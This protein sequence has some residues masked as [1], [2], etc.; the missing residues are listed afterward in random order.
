[1]KLYG[2]WPAKLAQVLFGLSFLVLFMARD[3]NA[4]KKPVP[5]TT[6]WSHRHLVFSTP[7]S[8]TRQIRLSSN[9]RYAQQSIR[10]NAQ[11]RVDQKGWRWRRAPEKP[12]LLQGDWSIYMGPGATVGARNYPAKYSFD[13]TSVRCAADSEG[14]LLPKPDFVVYNT[15]LPGSATQASILALT[16]L[17]VGTCNTDTVDAPNVYWAYNTGADGAV[18]TSTVLSGDGN[19]VAFVQNTAD[20]AKLVLLKWAA[21]DGSPSNP[22]TLTSQATAD[23]YHTC[24]A[25]CMYTMSF[26]TENG[27]MASTDTGSSPFYDY[28][29]DE[30]YAGDNYGF[31]HKFTGVFKGA[32]AEVVSTTRN[33][34]PANVVAGFNLRSPVFDDGTNQVFV[35]DVEGVLYRV[36]ATRGSGDCGR[37]SND[38]HFTVKLADAGFDDAPLV[39]STTGNVYVFARGDLGGGGSPSPNQRVGVFQ[40]HTDFPYNASATNQGAE[41]V[42]SSNNVL[43]VRFYAGDF[44]NTYYNSADGT[45]NLYVCGTNSGVMA[46]W[47]I[48][49]NAGVLGT[50]APGPTLTTAIA[51][52]SPV[53]EF[54]NPNITSPA[55]PNGTDFIFVGVAGSAQTN[56][57][58][59]CPSNTT[60]CIMSFDITHPAAWGGGTPT[61]ATAAVAGGSSAIVVDNSSSATG[62]SQIYFTP[63]ANQLCTT[64]GGTGG[65]AI[66]ASQAALR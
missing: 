50:P 33:I 8:L 25:P 39:D 34:W 31:L 5:M 23:D 57:T 30:L 42:V 38:C 27:G 60:G 4:G 44:D 28:A 61:S 52:C 47:R 12:T 18:V 55:N 66:Q 24:T 10:K 3:T 46:L 40:F 29:H 16:N 22:T 51:G 2:S 15:G 37:G 41:V 21:Y 63:L 14:N 59:N 7:K 1:M 43:P 62:A 53:T 35:C 56:A 26:S 6:D 54:F 20:A 17:Y 11:K 13:A 48:P 64:S 49:V 45:G 19:Q 9:P 65:C 36:D 58:I 32:P